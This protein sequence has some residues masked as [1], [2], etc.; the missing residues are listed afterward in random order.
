[1]GQ[2][3]GSDDANALGQAAAKAF[4][5]PFGA[6]LKLAPD[7]DPPVWIDGRSSPPKITKAIKRADCTWHGAPEVLIRALTGERAIESAFVA[8]RITIS[9]DIS[10][11]SRLTIEGPR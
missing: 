3:T 5:T 4:A 9:G 11:M 10:V 6:V 2:M 8:G 1:M 7:S